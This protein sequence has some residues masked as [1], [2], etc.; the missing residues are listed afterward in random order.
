MAPAVVAGDVLIVRW[1]GRVRAGAIVVARRPGHPKFLMVKRAVRPVGAAGWELAGDNPFGSAD[2]RQFG[3]VPV[4][5]V[6]ATV[7]WRYWPPSR[8]GPL[9]ARRVS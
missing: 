6:V 5:D 3:P 1:G 4:A 9:P 2:S 7:L 8:F